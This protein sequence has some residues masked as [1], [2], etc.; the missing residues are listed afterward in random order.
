MKLRISKNSKGFTLLEMALALGMGLGISAALLTMLQQQV[1]FTR[2]VSQFSFLRQEAP[3]INTLLANLL[4]GADSYR[5]YGDTANAKS[6]SNPIQTGGRAVR[7]RLR[8]PDGTI[9]H[10]IIAFE[11]QQ[12]HK[13]LNFYYRNYDQGTW[14]SDPSWTITSKPALVDFSNSSGILLITMTGPSGEEITY[15]GNPD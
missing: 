8:N 6:A 1:S 9:S 14:Q 5:I 11:N 4:H 12:G 2:I 13:R 3:Q 10:A 7:L 15:A